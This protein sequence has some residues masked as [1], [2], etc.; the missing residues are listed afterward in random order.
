MT[1]LLSFL[2]PDDTLTLG[3]KNASRVWR[4]FL[5]GPDL[6]ELIKESDLRFLLV[7]VVTL[8]GFAGGITRP[9]LQEAESSVAKEKEEVADQER[10]S[11]TQ[12]EQ[13]ALMHVM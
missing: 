5:L 6:E 8:R 13:Y 1:R 7:D 9:Q 10:S 3:A 11:V 12:S 2:F 4:G